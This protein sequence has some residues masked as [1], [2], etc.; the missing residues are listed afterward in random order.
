MFMV[1]LVKFGSHDSIFLKLSF[2][3]L[4]PNDGKV[5]L[6]ITQPVTFF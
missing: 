4:I 3:L 5:L 2:P 6:K 1:Q